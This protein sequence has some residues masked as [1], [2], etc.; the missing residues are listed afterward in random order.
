[1]GPVLGFAHGL[2]SL[3][4]MQ[5][6]LGLV[7]CAIGG[8][9]LDDWSGSASPLSK[10]PEN[11]SPAVSL[12]E[13]SIDRAVV[14]I[15]AAG[16]TSS[17]RAILW[18]QGETDAMDEDIAKSYDVSDTPM[19]HLYVCVCDD[20]F[21][22][23]LFYSHFPP[24]WSYV[25]LKLLQTRFST[26]VS[27]LR[28]RLNAT[29]VPIVVVAVTA[30]MVAGRKA[31]PGLQAVREAQIKL[32]SVSHEVTAAISAT[33]SDM[34]IAAD[35]TAVGNVPPTVGAAGAAHGFTH[36][37]NDFIVVD[38]AG[39]ALDPRD[40]L[41]L[42]RSAQ[43]KLGQ[44]IAYAL[45]A[46]EERARSMAIPINA[47]FAQ[48]SP[49]GIASLEQ[50]LALAALMSGG[51]HSQATKTGTATTGWSGG[52]WRWATRPLTTPHQSLLMLPVTEATPTVALATAALT[53]LQ[54]S[55]NAVATMPYEEVLAWADRYVPPPPQPPPESASAAGT[56]SAL[57]SNS[58]LPA[59][60][61]S[62]LTAVPPLVPKTD[63]DSR[64]KKAEV[65]SADHSTAQFPEA[66]AEKKPFALFAANPE[67]P[68]MV[69]FVYGE[70]LPSS[71]A[72]VLDAMAPNPGET[73]VDLGSGA[74]KTV[75]LA[76]LL[77][78]ALNRCVGLEMMR[79]YLRDA[80]A[81]SAVLLA[82]RQGQVSSAFGAADAENQGAKR[83]AVDGDELAPSSAAADAANATAAKAESL[84]SAPVEW[85][86]G[87]FL[88]PSGMLAWAS[89][90]LIVACSTC[91]DATTMAGIADGCARNSPPGARVLT[92]DKPLT[93]SRAQVGQ[94]VSVFL[95]FLM[96][97]TFRSA[98]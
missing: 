73:F 49:S 47:G 33:T 24:C 63:S 8:S 81:A 70:I 52:S 34:S 18:Y 22:C 31:L 41:H 68:K 97:G 93:T 50:E 60:H 29:R 76:G 55:Y 19:F 48:G 21:L 84:A 92:L 67:R 58:T 59:Q 23:P 17:L 28:S 43:L 32:A 87:D 27:S 80:Q 65:S 51:P 86:E 20:S 14:A 77:Y 56:S 38:A 88:S 4:A 62:V 91:F 1:V 54:D 95:F 64:A 2:R 98:Q 42:Q 53:A 85:W 72:A 10:N 7:P 57:S 61:E 37:V 12:L 74:G 66:Q 44:A 25:F 78:P 90:S 71:M 13:T 35:A 45:V 75:L 36:N 5:R 6:P 11:R 46:H 30:C 15:A 83:E 9:S 3:G 39:L 94:M 96:L 40:G 69:N 26:V 79:G 82:A 89:A 16:P